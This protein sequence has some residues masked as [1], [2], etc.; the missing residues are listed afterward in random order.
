MMKYKFTIVALIITACIMYAGITVFNNRY[1]SGTRFF[2]HIN[3]HSSDTLR[4]AYI[5]DSWAAFHQNHPCNIA[6][7]IEDSIHRPVIVESYGIC[8]ITSKAFYQSFFDNQDLKS[9]L[10]KGYDYCF[11]S[12]GINDTYKRT[13]ISDY[14]KG[15]DYTILFLLYNNIQPIILEI[16]D[17]N[18]LK[19]YNIQAF[20]RRCFRNTMSIITG[21]PL[22]C[23]QQYRNALDD[24]IR[25]KDY[26]GKVSIIRYKSWNNNYKND[27]KTLY[28]SDGMH[29]NHYGYDVLDKEIIKVILERLSTRRGDIPEEVTEK[30]AILIDTDEHFID[31]QANAIPALYNH[32]EEL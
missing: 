26:N 31:K 29:L 7:T 9:F 27:L 14:K 10:N 23:K 4:V 3:Q 25:E 2:Y 20:P 18:I 15:I 12:V 24:L 5:G 21:I 11:I 22:D 6:K 13:S 8:G 28:R 19:A 17:Y 16:P 32:P 30:N 1:L